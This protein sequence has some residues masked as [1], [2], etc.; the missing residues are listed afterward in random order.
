MER[1]VRRIMNRYR[2]QQEQKQT[3]KKKTTK[4]YT[5]SNGIRGLTIH[6]SSK[7]KT[8]KAALK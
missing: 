4:K 3:N 5:I 1:K 7:L 8:F 2:K 6:M